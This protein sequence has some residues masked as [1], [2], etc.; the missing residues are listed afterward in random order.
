VFNMRFAGQRHDP[1][2]GLSYNYYRDYDPV[3]G[4]YIQ[5]D[6]IGLKGGLSTYAY[7]GGNP[8]GTTDFFGLACP[9][10]LKAAGQC[11]DA[12]NYNP[13]QGNRSVIS[14]QATDEVFLA[15]G[16]RLDYSQDEE[17]FATISKLGDW[18]RVLAPTRETAKGVSADFDVDS[19]VIKAIC[20]SHPK[21]NRWESIPGYGDD[22][23]VKGGYPLYLVRNGVYGVLELD[24]GQFQY[25]VLKGALPFHDR[26]NIQQ[27]LDGFQEALGK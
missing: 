26:G 14:D 1:N 19:A 8:L 15:N 3:T 22:A 23:T 17:N 16:R 6:P 24:N 27:R 13:A 11:F 2:T 5:S 25:R 18:K 20:H 7:V 10:G 4:R 9:A 12:S 21:S